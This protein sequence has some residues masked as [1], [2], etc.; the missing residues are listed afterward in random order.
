[1]PFSIS[2]GMNTLAPKKAIYD[3]F[4]R[5]G[6]RG[7][8]LLVVTDLDPMG[9]TI[10]EDLV[11]SFRR[12]FGLENIEAFKVALT[13]DQVER[14]GLQPSMDAKESSPTYAAY[15]AK[16]G[17]RLRE[18]LSLSQDDPIPAFELEAMDPGDLANELREA[19]IDVLDID[20]YNQE[21]EA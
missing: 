2:R 9:D 1:M 15:V 14:F 16:Y 20:L 11:K 5:S 3:R 10:A 12:D 17:D 7:L 4:M 6:K 19:I 21:L 13:I 18:L 8:K